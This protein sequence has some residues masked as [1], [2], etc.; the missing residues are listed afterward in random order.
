ME[1]I[2]RKENKLLNR[3]ELSFRWNHSGSPTP[4]RSDMLNAISSVEPGSK[5]DLIVIKNVV[6]RFGV[7]Q[8]TGTG[9]VYNSAEAMTVE[10]QYIAKR[11]E[12]LR[13]TKPASSDEKATSGDVSGGEE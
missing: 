10:P 3:V 13:T 5:K 12:N 6:T 9:L 2:E 8:T 1:I 7:A 4:T 11:Y